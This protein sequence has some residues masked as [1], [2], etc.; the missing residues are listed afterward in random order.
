MDASRVAQAAQTLL[1]AVTAMMGSTL[2]TW[3]NQYHGLDTR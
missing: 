3:L 1:C 2:V